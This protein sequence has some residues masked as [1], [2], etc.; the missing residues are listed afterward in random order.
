MVIS[1]FVD[2]ENEIPRLSQTKRSERGRGREEIG[3][4]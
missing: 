4:C 2:Y 1:I 3:I